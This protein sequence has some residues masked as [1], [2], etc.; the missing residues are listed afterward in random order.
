MKPNLVVGIKIAKLFPDNLITVAIY[1]EESKK[2]SAALCEITGNA[3][4]ETVYALD[5]YLWDNKDDAL[6]KMN[7]VLENLLDTI[8]VMSN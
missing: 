4:G 5:D 8:K 7:N 1:D 3:I 2:W 6:F